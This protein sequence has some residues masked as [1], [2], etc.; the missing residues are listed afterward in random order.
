[1]NETKHLKMEVLEQFI[2]RDLEGCVSYPVERHLSCC[3]E[4]LKKLERVLQ[5]RAG[6]AHSQAMEFARAKTRVERHT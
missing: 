1:M 6:C 5:N 4:C 2:G 3:P